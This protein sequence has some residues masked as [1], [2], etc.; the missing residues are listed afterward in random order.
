[1][2]GVKVGTWACAEHAMQDMSSV[3]TTP[4]AMNAHT[5]F[6]AGI[7][8]LCAL[9]HRL[10]HRQPEASSSFQLACPDQHPS[11]ATAPGLLTCTKQYW[12]THATRCWCA[13]CTVHGTPASPPPSIRTTPISATHRPTSLQSLEPSF[14]PPSPHGL[15]PHPSGGLGHIR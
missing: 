4:G 10:P 12:A 6:A 7:C 1:M 9:M 3:M 14:P 15:S 13:L 11:S 8:F 2:S 5:G